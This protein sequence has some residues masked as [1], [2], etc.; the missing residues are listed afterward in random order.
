MAKHGCCWRFLCSGSS[1]GVIPPPPPQLPP[2]VSPALQ[3]HLTFP[4][5]SLFITVLVPMN[6]KFFYLGSPA[7]SLLFCSAPFATLTLAC[8]GGPTVFGQCLQGV[9]SGLNP[10]VCVTQHHQACGGRDGLHWICSGTSSTPG[11]GPLAVCSKGAV[12][13]D[14][15]LRRPQAIVL[16]ATA[17]PRV[18][19]DTGLAPAPRLW[20]SVPGKYPI[21]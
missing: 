17:G 14:R 7:G 18:V 15:Q 19:N 10:T 6:E 2:P 5:G 9:S 3:A 20:G 8:P 12:D 11:W 1:D 16:L 13:G 21:H 4:A